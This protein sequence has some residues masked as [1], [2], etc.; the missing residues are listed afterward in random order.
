VHDKPQAFA[1]KGF[2][3]VS[4]NYRLLP[5]ATIKQM[6]EDVAKA[7]RWVHDHARDHG[8]DPNTIIVMGHSA[9]AQLAALVCTDERYLKTEGLPLS[10]IKGCV[11]V[12][13]DTYDV[14]LQMAGPLLVLRGTMLLGGPASERVVRLGDLVSL[15]GLHNRSRRAGIWTNGHRPV[16]RT[17]TRW[18][19]AAFSL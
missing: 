17:P 15:F 1:D 4:V 8:G 19:A 11:P 18:A 14:P 5:K 12:D 10:V 13:G 9:G 6:A 16:G 7:I 3:F 2:V